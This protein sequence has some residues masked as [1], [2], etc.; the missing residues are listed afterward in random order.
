[1]SDKLKLK[2]KSVRLQSPNSD[3]PIPNLLVTRD[4]HF[5]PRKKK[6]KKLRDI[7]WVLQFARGGIETKDPVW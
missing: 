7:L 5:I 4:L 3:P 1:M 2:A 6:P